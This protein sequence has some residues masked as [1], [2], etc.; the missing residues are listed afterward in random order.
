MYVWV[1]SSGLSGIHDKSIDVTLVLAWSCPIMYVDNTPMANL[2]T[3]MVSDKWIMCHQGGIATGISHFNPIVKIHMTDSS[4]GFASLPVG[5][6][7]PPILCSQHW[8]YCTFREKEGLEKMRIQPSWPMSLILVGPIEPLCLRFQNISALGKIA[9]GTP[10]HPTTAGRK[11]QFLMATRKRNENSCMSAPESMQLILGGFTK[12]LV[13]PNMGLILNYWNP[14]GIPIMA[15][16]NL[17]SCSS[18]IE[19]MLCAFWS[20]QHISVWL[21][22]RR[23]ALCGI[24]ALLPYTRI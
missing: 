8:N 5:W 11:S 18:D 12:L 24:W 15:E 10:Q 2:C 7:L 23:K 22:L 9:R 19:Y 6:L 16:A 1:I 20:T 17:E 21:Y 14:R 3:L 13:L 4:I